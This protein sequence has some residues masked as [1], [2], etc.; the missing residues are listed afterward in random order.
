MADASA[1]RAGTVRAEE[2]VQDRAGS[3]D[4]RAR[5]ADRRHQSARGS[6][7]GGRRRLSRGRAQSR[8]RFH[9]SRSHEG[10]SRGRSHPRRRRSRSDA[11]EVEAIGL[12]AINESKNLLGDAI[13]S[14]EVRKEL[15]SKLEAVI[16][17]AMKPAEKIESIRMLHINGMPGMSGGGST[18]G[19]ALNGATEHNGNTGAGLPNRL[20]QALLQYRLQVPMVE[21]MLSE[22]G[23]S[24]DQGTL[25]P[26]GLGSSTRLTPTAESLESR[27]PKRARSDGCFH[28]PARAVL[29]RRCPD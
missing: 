18:N 20:V 28:L 6:R 15:V 13:L 3:R 9:T 27:A 22:L 2:E 25:V 10:E 12:K 8:R 26:T 5:Q 24:L 11:L 7:G 16:A 19:G 1:A 17:A 21:K 4:G 23:L 14:L 29:A